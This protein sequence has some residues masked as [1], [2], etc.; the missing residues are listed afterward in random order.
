LDLLGLVRELPHQPTKVRG[1]PTRVMGEPTQLMEEPTQ[2]TA[3]S[4]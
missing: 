2:L 4:D 3:P 1:E